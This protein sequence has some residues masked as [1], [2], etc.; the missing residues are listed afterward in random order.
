[1]KLGCPTMDEGELDP[2]GV[3]F[4]VDPHPQEELGYEELEEM[5]VAQVVSVN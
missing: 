4:D 2:Q 3:Q 1:M 5:G